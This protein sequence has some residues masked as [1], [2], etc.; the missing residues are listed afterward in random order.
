MAKPE[1]WN[2]LS[3]R[4]KA[5]VVDHLLQRPERVEILVREF[6][7]VGLEEMQNAEYP[8]ISDIEDIEM[9]LEV[10][11]QVFETVATQNGE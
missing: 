7:T 5:E 9:L 2:Q 1:N 11:P 6:L 4:E 10:R 8:A 3:P